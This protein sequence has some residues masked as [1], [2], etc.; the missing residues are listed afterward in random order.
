MRIF[1]TQ[2]GDNRPVVYSLAQ[3][4]SGDERRQVCHTESVG[5][6]MDE[7]NPAY[8]IKLENRLVKLA[9]ENERLKALN[10]KYRNWLP[11]SYYLCNEDKQ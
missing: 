5:I 2:A 6:A 9:I 8:V 3:Y 4:V 11:A 1:R 10:E 7:M